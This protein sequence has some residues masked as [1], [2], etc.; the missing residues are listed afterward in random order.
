M[1]KNPEKYWPNRTSKTWTR[2]NSEISRVF[3]LSSEKVRIGNT[4]ATTTDLDRNVKTTDSDRCR[5]RAGRIFRRSARFRSPT[6]RVSTD[7]EDRVPET[8][9]FMLTKKRNVK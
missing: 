5:D 7:P 4:P 6:F 9:D 8:P 2:P 1:S 3:R